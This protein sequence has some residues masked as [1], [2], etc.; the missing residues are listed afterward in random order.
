MTFDE[1]TFTMRKLQRSGGSTN[2]FGEPALSPLLFGELG[3]GRTQGQP[4]PLGPDEAR[5]APPVSPGDAGPKTADTGPELARTAPIRK[6]SRGW[7]PSAGLLNR[8]AMAPPSDEGAQG[9]GEGRARTQ[10]ETTGT[11][12][13]DAPDGG[14]SGRKVLCGKHATKAVDRCFSVNDKTLFVET[15]MST[16]EIRTHRQAMLTSDARE[17]RDSEIKEYLS[18]E[19][20]KTFSAPIPEREWEEL[21]RQGKKVVPLQQLYVS[22]RDGRRKARVVLKGFLLKKGVH[23]NETFAPV[24]NVEGFRIFFW[25][26]ACYR[27]IVTLLDVETAYLFPKMDTEMYARLPPAFNS[28]PDLQ[29]DAKMSASVHR[30][31]KAVP[32][33]PQCSRLWHKDADGTLKGLGFAPVADCP[34]L[35]RIPDTWIL[36]LL[37]VD[38]FLTAHSPSHGEAQRFTHIQQALK[39][40]YEGRIRAE[41][42]GDKLDVLGV[43]VER[44]HPNVVRLHQKPYVMKILEDAGMRNSNPVPTPNVAGTQFSKNDCPT[45]GS[46]DPAVLAYYRRFLACVLYLYLWTRV[47]LGEI[48]GKLGRFMHNP[49][50][51]MV[52]AL[53]RVLR[54]LRGSS[55]WGLVYDFTR[56]PIQRGVYG[57]FDSSHADDVDTRRS[58]MAY[59]FFVDGCTISWHSKRHSYDVEQPQ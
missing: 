5:S 1:E 23:Y 21:Q 15:A 7:H 28:D 32:G 2:I 9:D 55:D 25:A 38:D 31:L 47:E 45:P 50:E 43:V 11:T 54:F 52:K 10:Q 17:W 36:V 34:C 57:Y 48:V 16:G 19:V 49:G 41:A 6:S 8:I 59:V 35:Y 42:L 14:K 29:V 46:A 3:H 53:K 13:E 39:E 22:K 33:A 40:K 4:T 27:L 56:T 44:P 24:P 30:I 26:V 58:T 37:W 51:K 12:K 18:H 20:N